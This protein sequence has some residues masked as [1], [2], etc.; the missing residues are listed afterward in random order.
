M[1]TLLSFLRSPVFAWRILRGLFVFDL[2]HGAHGL[3]Q[4]LLRFFWELPQVLVGYAVAQWRNV[5][6]RV[7]RVE[8]LG[9]VTF[10]VAQGQCDGIN[11]GMSLGC[12]VNIWLSGTMGRDFEYEVRYSFGQIFMHEFGH[13]IDSL[14][15]GWIYLI[16]VGLPSLISVKL[17]GFRG[18][19]HKN[20]YAER[21]ADI[22]AQHYFKIPITDLKS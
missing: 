3:A 18:H 19:R 1:I 2:D 16:A 22:N 13:T 7:N 21:W 9:G 5:L 10:V 14:R 11:M 17:E 6:G 20:L 15:L 4:A 8:Y 12:Y